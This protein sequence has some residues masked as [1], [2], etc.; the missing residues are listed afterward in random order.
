MDS[1]EKN[2]GPLGDEEDGGGPAGGIVEPEELVAEE[3]DEALAEYPSEVPTP[4]PPPPPPKKK[5]RGIKGWVGKRAKRVVE[6]IYESKADE[7]EER[8]KRV[9]S[10]A[11]QDS[12][13]DI[14]ERAVR[15]MRRAIALE[16]DRIKEVI[17]HSVQVKKREV[18]L[19]LI[20]LLAASILYLILYWSTH[21]GGGQ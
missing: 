7:L 14:E 21:G 16:A 2:K 12:A 3:F 18:R 6:R 15:A 1:V 17:E 20:V 13:E 4:A 11:Y 5:P 8:A 10:S 19:S 9:V